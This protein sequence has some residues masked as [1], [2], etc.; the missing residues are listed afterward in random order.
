MSVPGL[1]TMQQLLD[2]AIDEVKHW[3]ASPTVA[4]IPVHRVTNVRDKLQAL[5]GCGS[6]GLLRTGMAHVSGAVAALGIPASE[7]APSL[8][9]LT[10]LL[11]ERQRT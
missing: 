3:Q 11:D 10:S 8:L 6:V 1:S 2:A 7:F 4:D 5:R 9:Q